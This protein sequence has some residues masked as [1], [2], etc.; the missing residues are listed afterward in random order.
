MKTNKLRLLIYSIILFIAITFPVCTAQTNAIS[1]LQD[2]EVNDDTIYVRSTYGQT[3]WSSNVGSMGIIFGSNRQPYHITVINSTS[4]TVSLYFD[5]TG[6]TMYL[7]RGTDKYM[8]YTQTYSSKCVLTVSDVSASSVRFTAD[9]GRNLQYVYM[10]ST[11]WLWANDSNDPGFQVFI[12]KVNGSD[13]P[14]TAPSNSPTTPP[15]TKPSIAPL[16][17][18]SN[19]PSIPPTLTPTM[20]PTN[21]PTIE[22]S[23]QLKDYCLRTECNAL[24]LY[25]RIKSQTNKLYHDVKSNT[26]KLS[27]I[28]KKNIG[29][30]ICSDQKMFQNKIT[31]NDI[32]GSL[33]NYTFNLFQ[34]SYEIKGCIEHIC[35]YSLFNYLNSNVSNFTTYL[36]GD[37]N[38]GYS[39]INVSI[40][41]MYLSV[42]PKPY[43]F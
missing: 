2:V 9:D 1:L 10:S 25:L 11:Y 6:T 12:I 28:I 15:T 42:I 14:T 39:N 16:Y 22:L 41:G 5:S 20:S 18:P 37:I 26:S 40:N 31:V 27:N 4:N 32:N 13:S 3:Y 30:H 36:S 23:C 7:C 34:T 8:E 43:T 19:S 17:S 24:L 21:N 35:D 33:K 29:Q 38:N